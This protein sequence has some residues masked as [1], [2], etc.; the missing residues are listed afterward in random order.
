MIVGLDCV[1]PAIVFDD[2]RAELPVLSGLMD[3]GAWG[4]LESC[5]PPITVPAWTCMMSSKDPG[6][7]GFYGFRNRADH[8]YD[9]MTFATSEKV[10]DDRLWDILSRAGRHSVVLG[11]PQTF[12][13]HPLNGE[14]V[15]CFLTPSIESTY[16][17]P[18]ELR[19]E[20][21]EVVGEY[22]FDV[23][24]FR[25]D[26]RERILRDI[27]E[28]TR[29]RFQLARHLR[30]TR[31]W[32]L[33]A[34]V[35]MGTDRLHHAL[36]RYYD[37]RHPDY[38]PEN[39]FEQ[40]FRGY[41]RYLDSEVGSLIEGLGDDTA[42]L[43][44]SDHGAQSMF[45]GVQINEWLMQHGYL[46]L[47][48]PPSEATP[49]GRCAIDWANT[50]V[51]ADGGYYSRIFLNIA[52]REPQG[53]VPPGQVEALRDELIAGL[54]GLGD[55]A[56]SPI[57]TRVYRPGDLYEIANGFPPDLIAYFG[58][59]T[60]RAIGSVGDGRVH[61]RENDTGPDDANHAKH[62]IAILAGPGMPAT[63]PDDASLYDI[64]PTVLTALGQPVPDDMRGRVLG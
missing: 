35:E 1:D 2:M 51:W 32:D 13:V 61:V 39:P 62:G 14:M 10:H 11:V 53:I 42:L 59:L 38:E 22:M 4:R 30:D 23:P 17:Y 20:I 9:K 49:I 5:D 45:G 15:S 36:W 47:I 56:G 50:R 43:V 8:S 58:N 27:H 18:A 12:P 48:D 16:T 31:D 63:L 25:T 34:M 52:G 33:F 21:R 40:G 54:E 7:L 3:R 46:S 41:Y 24:D 29:R 19:D 57:G 37:P 60:W 26:Q 44:V 28:M 55:E 64:A 6:R